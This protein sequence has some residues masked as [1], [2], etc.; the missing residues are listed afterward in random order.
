MVIRWYTLYIFIFFQNRPNLAN[1]TQTQTESE[2][3][4]AH[5]LV[6]HY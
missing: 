5:V 3:F 6:A 4:Q 1:Y 2:A